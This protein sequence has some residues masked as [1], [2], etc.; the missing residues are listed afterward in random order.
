MPRCSTS[1]R[2]IP[3]TNSTLQPDAE[4]STRSS[5][6][7]P[8]VMLAAA[9]YCAHVLPRRRSD[10][11]KRTVPEAASCSTAERRTTDLPAPGMPPICTKPGNLAASTTAWTLVSRGTLKP[12]MLFVI[13]A[14]ASRLSC[15]MAS[16]A[17]CTLGAPASR[18]APFRRATSVLRSYPAARPCETRTS[19]SNLRHR[20]SARGRSTGAR[21]L[22]RPATVCASVGE[23]SVSRSRRMRTK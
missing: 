2:S 22:A 15:C 19:A 21:V 20:S 23:P 12:E 9:A 3:S 11:R 5:S 8:S 14:A 4:S 18:K 6:K 10:F 13:S 17:A 16:S 1:T 7:L